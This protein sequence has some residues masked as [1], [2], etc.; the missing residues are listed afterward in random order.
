MGT[1]NGSYSEAIAALSPCP[2]ALGSHGE[3]DLPDQEHDLHFTGLAVEGES[4]A[5]WLPDG[6]WVGWGVS[7]TEISL[8]DQPS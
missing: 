1:A 4:G 6:V 3:G 7:H 5:I 8:C 2:S